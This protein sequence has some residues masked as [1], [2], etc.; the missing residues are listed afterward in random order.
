MALN[1]ERIIK[2]LE[3][4][5]A[6]VVGLQH[7]L[8]CHGEETPELDK[9]IAMIH[10]AISLIKEL[11]EENERLQ[12]LVKELQQYNEA[13]V[14]DNGKLRQ[15]MKTLKANTVQKM[16]AM[17]KA[18]SFRDVPVFGEPY[19]CVDFVIIDQ[20]AKEMLEESK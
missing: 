13:W 3:E 18:R 4:E 14:E 8:E 19:S 10:G 17:L 6:Y 12:A 2:M 16:R 11:T 5:R 20:V 15:E 1:R 7:R 9:Q